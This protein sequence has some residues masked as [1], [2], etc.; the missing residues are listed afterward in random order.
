MRDK[1]KTLKDLKSNFGGSVSNSE[2]RAEAIKWVKKLR[3]EAGSYVYK[4]L[5]IQDWI[6][7]FFNLK[8][9]DLK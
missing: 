2:L 7:H 9:E 1:L 8:E 6:K 4:N 3:E 5:E